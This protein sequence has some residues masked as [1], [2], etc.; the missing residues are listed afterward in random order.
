MNSCNEVSR[1]STLNALPVA[2]S[3]VR[4]GKQAF[5]VYTATI[6]VLA[7]QWCYVFPNCL[8]STK[9]ACGG[10]STCQSFR[11]DVRCCRMTVVRTGFNSR[12]YSVTR[13]GHWILKERVFASECD[14][15]R[16]HI[17]TYTILTILGY[18]FQLGFSFYS[19]ILLTIFKSTFL[20]IGHLRLE[21]WASFFFLLPDT[22]DHFH[23]TIHFEWSS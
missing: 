22:T 12:I 23:T 15:V 21:F 16:N 1:D 11:T 6:G 4:A 9:N 13:E 8:R 14:V 10:W 18:S 20:S 17:R 3:P 5:I 7:L 2:V 19:L